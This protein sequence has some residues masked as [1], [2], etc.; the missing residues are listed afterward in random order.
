[1]ASR[2]PRRVVV[3][4]LGRFG[5]SL[6][7][8]LEKRDVPVL[9]IDVDPDIV[10]AHA[11]RLRDVV[12]ADA[13]THEA[14][15]QL[16]VGPDTRVVIAMS[17]L[18]ASLLTMTIVSELDVPE[19]WAKAS[20]PT[21]ARILR[22]LGAQHVVQ[23]EHEMGS[24]VSHLLTGQME[25]YLEFDDDFAFA[26][27]SVPRFAAGRPLGS[28]SIRSDYGIT[29]VAVKRPGQEIEYATTE[30]VLEAGDV[31]IVSGRTTQVDRF[32]Q[33]T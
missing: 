15:E 4:G 30:T 23:P 14:L 26:K 13:T 3:I 31:L 24:R 7:L 6:A 9:G 29:V 2:T 17:G 5:S 8:A 16:E 22:R 20:S 21:H 25:D 32:A 18:Q 12:V 19:V 11:E 33:S 28:T 27:T 10:Q 1:M